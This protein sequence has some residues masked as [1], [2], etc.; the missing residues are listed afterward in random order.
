MN[1]RN[2]S[3]LHIETELSR[4]LG[5][6]S[7]LSIG[8][9]T[10]IA[11]GIFTLSGL[12]VRDVGSSAVIAFLVAAL[13][14]GFTALTYCEFSSLYPE[15]GEGYLYARRTFPP[16]LAYLVGWTLVL[17]Y[18]S[19]CA[20]Y[21]SSLSSYFNEFVWHSPYEQISGTIGLICLILLNIKGTKE[22]ARF[23]ILITAGKVILLFWFVYGGLGNLDTK[24]LVERMSTDISK[25]GATAGLVFI[26]FFGFSAI[27]ASAGEVT[28]PTKTIPR[29]IFLSMTI[30]TI[31]YTLVV[32][33]IIAANLTEYTEAAMGN[34]ARLFLGPIGGMVIIV[35][36][37]FSMISA[38]NASI[39]AGSRVVLSMAQLGHLPS[40]I[41]AIN[42]KTRTP[43]ISLI[44]VGGTI[45][46]FA[47]SFHLEKLAHFADTILLLALILVNAALIYNR[48]KFPNLL[49]HFRVPFV[50]LLPLM[51]IAANIY[52]LSLILQHPEPVIMAV[53]WLIV[54]M[55]GFLAWKG[56]Q[57]EEEFLPGERSRVAQVSMEGQESDFRV[58][59][60]IANPTN[61][62]PL[63]DLAS[64]IAKEN[65]G[66][67]V[68]MRVVSLPEQAPTSRETSYVERERRILEQAHVRAKSHGVKVSS[69]VTI[70]RNPARA[71]LETARERH[72]DLIVLGWKGYTSTANRILGE[73]VDDV[74]N[75]ARADIML[76]KL[77]GEMKYKNI[78]LPTTGGIH[79][80][81]AERY[82]A[83]IASAYNARL[84]V[85]TVVS[86]D[87]GATHNYSVEKSL[88]E[89]VGRINDESS[90]HVES[91]IIA[92]K[93][94]SVGIIQASEKYD[95]IALGAAGESF[96]KQILF[97]SI[98]EN[99]AK[100]TDKT[101]IVYKQYSPVKALVG[102]VMES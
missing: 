6:A 76:V 5:L 74:V 9:G 55:L 91:Q 86:P 79:A 43:I 70:G 17:G 81:L 101:V 45:I 102:R 97:G 52:L 75:L 95:A 27:A 36:A 44:L 51:G 85:S 7:A 15:S 78:L 1:K 29:A 93:S 40:G 41:A 28:N 31:L 61:V 59:V 80:R 65:D 94:V 35:G 2:G 84:V 100:H 64:A 37:L 10:M 90:V 38:S 20:F 14:A 30:V 66:E 26:T 22:S 11:A 25:I 48:K 77:V 87:A 83:T 63:I 92:H 18:T 34:A 82:T 96:Y 54:G 67:I 19:S 39:L 12:A 98:P 21:I 16:P 8:V 32:F 99:V 47:Q 69:L 23:Q 13:V 53:L 89:A 72:C 57:A 24:A 42:P 62:A 71:I 88:S 56:S 58:L 60:P 50:P 4:D 3:N 49:R 73:I 46:V 33:V 68:A